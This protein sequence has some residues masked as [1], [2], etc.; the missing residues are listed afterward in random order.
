MLGT[1]GPVGISGQVGKCIALG[2]AH[3]KRKRTKNLLLNKLTFGKFNQ[4]FNDSLSDFDWVSSDSE[5]VQKYM[6]DPLCGLLQVINF[7]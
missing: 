4:A 6:E 7:L 5:S 1:G 2:F 3:F